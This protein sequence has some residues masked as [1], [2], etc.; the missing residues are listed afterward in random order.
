MIRRLFRSLILILFPMLLLA[1]C[2]APSG[3]E[4]PAAKQGVLDLR[5]W[6][7]DR[8]GELP[9]TGEWTFFSGMLLS[10]ELAMKDNGKHVTVP[11]SWNSYPGNSGIKNGQGYATYKLS[12]LIQPTDRVL[13]VRVPNIFSSYRFWI[14]GKLLAEQGIVGTSRSTSKAQQFPRIVSFHPDG[15]QQLD[16]VV[17]VSNFQHRKGGIWVPFKMGNSDT[18]VANQM[19][20]SV[21]E[22]LILGSLL[23]IGIYHIGLYAFRRQE[24]FTIHF[25]LLCLFIAARAGVT[26]ENYILQLIPLSWEIGMK[27]EYIAF[28][29]SALAGYLYVYRLFP[30]DASKR[31]IPFVIGIGTFLVGFVLFT[32]AIVYTKQISW[33][34]IFVV[35]VSIY[36]LIVLITAKIRKR[37]GSAFVLTGVAV[38]VVTVLNDML[39]YNEWF[40]YAQLIPLGLFFFMLMQSFIISKRFSSAM[41]RAEHVSSELRELNAHLEERIEER[42]MELS[43]A[44]ESLEQTNRVLHRSESSR[45]HLMTNISHDLRTPITLLQG[46]LE[47]FQDGVVK[48]EEQQ[49]RYLRMMLGKVGGL[50]RLIHDLFELTKLEAGQTRFD[51]ANVPLGHWIQQLHDLYEID[52]VSS[53]M[54]FRCDFHS[55]HSEQEGHAHE[56]EQQNRIMLRLDLPRMDQVIANVIYNAIKHTEKGG[57]IALSFFFDETANRT[58]VTVSDTGSGIEEEH[59]PF[60]FDRFYKKEISRNSAEGGSGLGL[61]IAKEIVEA[62]GGTIG[63]VSTLDKGTMIWFAL[64]ATL[65]SVSQLA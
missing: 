30:L 49:Q 5:N 43:A 51:F 32:P 2:S 14:D 61:A 53:G 42:T 12:V 52:V 31:V 26:G 41:Y 63:A 36:T 33:F 21:Q 57:E 60:I 20:A 39:F 4:N 25:G 29:L 46:Y 64:P 28:S 13:A 8:D 47:A 15:K 62:H 22:I 55:A 50:N 23:I 54:R 59:L 48:T 38:F 6:S 9:L 27:I 56:M 10:P 1:G 7:F 16:F 44:N 58:I 65:R 34:Q 17:Q 3:G 11:R 45:R 35:A 40:L 24:Q 19:K 18:L 37:I